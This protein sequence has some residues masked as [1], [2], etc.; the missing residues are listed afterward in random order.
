MKLIIKSCFVGLLVIGALIFNFE[1]ARAADSVSFV[2]EIPLSGAWDVV[3]KNDY[4]YVA[5]RYGGLKIIDISNPSTPTLVNTY[6]TPGEAHGIDL[7]GNYAYI[8]DFDGGLRIINISNPNSLIEE[9]Y[10]NTSYTHDVKVLNNY[11]YIAT[12]DPALEIINISNPNSP[13]RIGFYN[14]GTGASGIAING[15]YAYLNESSGMRIIDIGNPVTPTAKDYHSLNFSLGSFSVQGN[16][17]YVPASHDGLKILDVSDPDNIS[18]V[19]YYD[20]INASTFS[21]SVLD[22]HAFI[23]QNL[24]S[25]ESRFE[26]IDIQSPATPIERVSYPITYG[27]VTGVYATN[28]YVYLAYGNPGKLMIL[29]PSAL[30][31]PTTTATSTPTTTPTPTYTT[32]ASKTPTPTI[33]L[34]PIPQVIGNYMIPNVKVS[35]NTVTTS[36][37]GKNFLASPIVKLQKTGEPDITAT[38]VIVKS[39]FLLTCVF[40]LVNASHGIYDLFLDRGNSQGTLAKSFTVLR[41]ITETSKWQVKDIGACGVPLVT[42]RQNGITIADPDNDTHNELYITNRNN[43]F[44]QWSFLGA[45]WARNDLPSAVGTERYHDVLAFD[46]DLDSIPELY[47]AANDHHVYSF[48]GPSYT[49]SDLGFGSGPINAL[50]IGDGNNDGEIELYGASEDGHVYQFKWTGSSWAQVDMGIAAGSLKSVTVGDGNNDDQFEVYVAS[51]DH[52][53]YQYKFTSSW[54]ITE[55]GSGAGNM[56]SVVV[57]NL[58]QSQDQAVYGANE[59][60]N[61]YQFKKAPSDWDAVVIANSN[62]NNAFFEIVASDGDN[63]GLTRLYGACGDGNIYQFD[64]SAS[65]WTTTIIGECGTPLYD[66]AI[67][68][69]R[70]DYHHELFAIGENSH[71]YELKYES[72]I[73]TPTPTATVTATITPIDGFSGK[74]IDKKYTYFA[75]NPVRG[76]NMKFVVHVPRQCSIEGKLYTTSNKFVLSFN[77][78]CPGAGKYE[79]EEYVGNLANGVYLLLVKAK[80]PDGTSERLVKKLGLIK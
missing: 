66:L 28:T 29:Y 46:K 64:Y 72:T 77:L 3:V 30:S 53:I 2:G 39:S 79:H 55:I 6:D 12:N 21:L 76:K 44:Y 57:A 26:V 68:D 4:A 58:E 73:A 38:N 63:A 51:G 8:A 42:G 10:Y 16:Y 52:K 32:T 47:M 62:S 33:T 71:V 7:S 80:S 61:I 24:V 78:D 75:P 14:S 15:N 40:D 41:P 50:A 48:S 65:N 37:I 27:A 18:E 5:D 70:N 31:T 20:K 60:G 56:T 67:G 23:I 45:S 19:G 34:T 1:Q 49:K 54:A 35:N 25:S 9:G 43:N 11:A 13:S 74:L 17:A 22:N 36:I 59:D 69:G